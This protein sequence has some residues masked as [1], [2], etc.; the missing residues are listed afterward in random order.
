MS[1][2]ALT[3]YSFWRSSAAYRVRIALNL[4]G[5]AYSTV[6]TNLAPGVLEQKSEAFRRVNPQG[7]VP[8]LVDQG[9]VLG[10]SLAI[11]EYLEE[12][13]PDP[14]LLPG[15]PLD[16]ARIRALALAVWSRTSGIRTAG[17]CPGGVWTAS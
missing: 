4:K 9:T 7:F 6:A 12:I 17:F 2:P 1:A 16:R 10:E 13:Q 3:L 11:I 15:T 5:L 8:A 14:R